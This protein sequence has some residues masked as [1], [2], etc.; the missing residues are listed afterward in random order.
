MSLAKDTDLDTSKTARSTISKLSG[1]ERKRIQAAIRKAL[2]DRDL[3]KFQAALIKLGYD[4]TSAEYEKLMK[5]WDEH[6]RA[7]RHD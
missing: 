2:N 4:E 6:A 3:P 1:D 7:S 5:L